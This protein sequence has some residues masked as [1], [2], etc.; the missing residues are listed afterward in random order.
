[1]LRF[2]CFQRLRL[3]WLLFSVPLALSVP[4]VT[5]AGTAIGTKPSTSEAQDPRR[6]GMLGTWTRSDLSLQGGHF[7][8]VATLPSPAIQPTTPF[9]N[10]KSLHQARLL[11]AALEIVSTVEN[12]EFEFDS[13]SIELQ[14]E[15]NLDSVASLLSEN[16]EISLSLAGHTDLMGSD[17]YNDILS[18]FRVEAVR[19]ALVARGV[20]SDRLL[21]FAFGESNPLE[22]TEAPL[23]KNRRVEATISVEEPIYLD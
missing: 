10:W 23:R 20:D 1:M 16:P 2:T 6:P 21:T 22:A 8:V 3:V 15:E 17:E 9:M 5:L 12:I 18:S 13:A 19:R 7:G 14:Y 4:S 11:S